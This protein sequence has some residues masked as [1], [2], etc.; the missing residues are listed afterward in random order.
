VTETIPL[1]PL[2]TVVFP[3]GPLRLRIFE[4]RYVDMIGRSMRESTG[5]GVAS[6]VE[7]REAGPARTANV[8]TLVRIVDF[9]RL[10]DGLLGISARGERRFRID[11]VRIQ[12]DGLNVAQ[13]DWLEPEPTV[14]L[15]GRHDALV[16]VLRQA[17]P[18]LIT[19]YGDIAEHWDDA[20]WVG[21]RLAEILPLPLEDKQRLLE[22]RAPLERLETIHTKLSQLA[23]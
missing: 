15:A 5:F 17:L 18:Q 23:K 8:G 3:D 19:L 6:I 20:S 7:G 21:M 13:V 11:I 12:N 10:Q 22:L 1:F 4:P 2:S 9:E 14:S 16:Q